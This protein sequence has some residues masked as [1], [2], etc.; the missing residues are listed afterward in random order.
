MDPLELHIS[1]I[2]HGIGS[3]VVRAAFVGTV[4][5]GKGGEACA[6][7]IAEKIALV[8]G[9]DPPDAVVVDLTALGE[10]NADGLAERLHE[11]HAR[12]RG[13]RLAVVARDPA[14]R[15]LE[16]AFVGDEELRSG[17]ARTL[18]A[19]IRP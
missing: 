10:W 4:P 2:G 18:E 12:F 13:V 9:G 3:R 15:E 8:C 16:T 1:L 14:F 11:V 17:L 5:P 7:F 19:V 6:D